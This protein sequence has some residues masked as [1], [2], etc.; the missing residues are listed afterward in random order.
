MGKFTPYVSVT[1]DLNVTLVLKTVKASLD[2]ERV[3]KNSIFDR[4]VHSAGL[5]EPCNRLSLIS[6]HPE[7]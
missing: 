6:L 3:D 7:L 4:L 5:G 1:I 2:N